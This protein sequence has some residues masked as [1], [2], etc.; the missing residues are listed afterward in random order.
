MSGWDVIKVEPPGIGD[1]HRY[2]YKAPP[3]PVCDANYFRQLT[4]R[5]KRSIAFDLKSEQAKPVLQRLVYLRWK[6]RYHH[7][8]PLDQM[9][10]GEYS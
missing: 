10:G 7:V 5:N 6:V 9:M 2:S 1:P 8:G 3:L 4:N